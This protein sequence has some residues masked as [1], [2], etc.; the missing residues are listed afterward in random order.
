M[1]AVA[2]FVLVHSLLGT[3][4]WSTMV[5]QL[6]AAVTIIVLVLSLLEASALVTMVLLRWLRWR[7]SCCCC[8]SRC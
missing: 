5:V 7:P 4:T 3:S 8:C 6:I 2:T 1:A